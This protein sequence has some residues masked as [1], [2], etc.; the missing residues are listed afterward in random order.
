MYIGR[1]LDDGG[2]QMK[3]ESLGWKEDLIFERSTF[4]IEAQF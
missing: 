2:L 3:V 1:L 4:E